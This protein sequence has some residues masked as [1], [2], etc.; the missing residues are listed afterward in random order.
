MLADP[1]G[2]LLKAQIHEPTVGK[3]YQVGDAAGVMGVRVQTCAQV[4][5]TVDVTARTDREAEEL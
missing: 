3:I 4:Y 2:W 1:I 5:E